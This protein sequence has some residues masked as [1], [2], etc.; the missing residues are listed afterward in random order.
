FEP[1][2]VAV[3]LAVVV[4]M[5]DLVLCDAG[6]RIPHLGVVGAV[7]HQHAALRR[8]LVLAGRDHEA[9]PLLGV[10]LLDVGDQLDAA[11]LDHAGVRAA[12]VAVDTA[13]LVGAALQA[14]AAVLGAGQVDHYWHHKS[15][16]HRRWAT[17][18]R[19]QPYCLSSIAD[20]LT[21]YRS[22]GPRRPRARPGPAP[23]RVSGG[24]GSCA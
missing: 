8:K 10:A 22:P 24:R 6:Y 4:H 7:H 11:L 12:A 18:D 9:E 17:D 23:R 5:D 14:G 16:G 1:L 19:I 21:K 20:C 2:H 15:P 3:E 13:A